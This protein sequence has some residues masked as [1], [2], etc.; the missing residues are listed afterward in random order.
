[1]LDAEPEGFADRILWWTGT[2][3]I[4]I[5][6]WG[7]IR[8]ALKRPGQLVFHFLAIPLGQWHKTTVQ[9]CVSAVKEIDPGHLRELAEQRER[10][11]QSLASS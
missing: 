10:R 2:D 11:R 6:S 1:M 3:I 9:Q 8:S 5:E 7:E 4:M